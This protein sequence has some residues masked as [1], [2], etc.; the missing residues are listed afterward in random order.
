M[1]C[2]LLVLFGATGLIAELLIAMYFD[3]DLNPWWGFLAG[4]VFSIFYSKRIRKRKR[5]ALKEYAQLNGYK[6]DFV[7]VGCG[8]NSYAVDVEKRR[9]VFRFGR[10]TLDYSWSD[11]I[12]VEHRSGR[13]PFGTSDST[14]VFTVKDI[15]SPEV[16][17]S[18]WGDEAK[19]MFARL[20]AAGMIE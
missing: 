13:S 8:G 11:I 20:K 17:F 3:L 12:Q 16:E 19:K 7:E 1:G 2:L 5:D 15:R 4:A 14:L 9:L 18:C 10:N 6:Y